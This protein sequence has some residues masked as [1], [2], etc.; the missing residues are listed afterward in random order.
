MLRFA[1]EHH[2]GGRHDQRVQQHLRCSATRYLQALSAMLNRL[3][4]L[5]AQPELVGPLSQLRDHR[6]QL[7]T[8]ARG[9]VCTP[10][11]RPSRRPPAVGRVTGPGYRHTDLSVRT[12]A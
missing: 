4:P 9:G 5:A 3:E 6:Q 8:P 12:D 10:G 1:A 7:R 11:W 2:P